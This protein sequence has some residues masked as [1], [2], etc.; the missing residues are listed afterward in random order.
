MSSLLRVRYALFDD[1]LISEHERMSCSLEAREDAE[2]I[3][4]GGT[5]CLTRAMK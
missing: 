3:R 4:R 2:R 1:Y 5:L